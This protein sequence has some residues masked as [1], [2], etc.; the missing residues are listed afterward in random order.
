MPLAIVDGPQIEDLN[1][2][3]TLVKEITDALE[4]AYGIKR[5]SYIVIVRESLPENVAVAGELILDRIRK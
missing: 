5:E 1:L 2:K 4:K 3:R